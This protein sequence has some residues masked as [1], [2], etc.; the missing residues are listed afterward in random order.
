MNE[1]MNSIR[2]ILKLTIACSQINPFL[3]Y[4]LYIAARVLIQNL[5]P[6]SKDSQIIATLQ[7]IMAAMHSFKRRNPFTGSFLT[8]LEVD[9]EGIGIDVL[10]RTTLSSDFQQS[11]RADPGAFMSIFIDPK[12][13]PTEALVNSDT[14]KLTTPSDAYRFQT[15]GI[16]L[17][18]TEL[19]DEGLT[20]GELDCSGPNLQFVHAQVPLGM[21]AAYGNF[22]GD[23]RSLLEHQLPSRS[24]DSPFGL[25]S[26]QI[27]QTGLGESTPPV[28]SYAGYSSAGQNHWGYTERDLSSHPSTSHPFQDQR[29][30]PYAGNVSNHTPTLD[31]T[32]SQQSIPFAGSLTEQERATREPWNSMGQ[33]ENLW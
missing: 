32:N 7:L 12:P 21:D 26:Q 17:D 28:T 15:S 2:E 29:P 31:S 9:M 8:Q 24:H 5:K 1:H 33:S 27:H 22:L 10:A 20:P 18:N 13:A 23:G 3:A 11:G 6:K 16:V 4:C 14:E 19:R 25:G 30:R